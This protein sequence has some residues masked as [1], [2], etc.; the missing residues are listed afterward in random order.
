MPPPL[1]K[2]LWD[3]L[4]SHQISIKHVTIVND[5]A[6][7]SQEFHTKVALSSSPQSISSKTRMCRW[8]SSG[9]SADDGGTSTRN[10]EKNATW[11]TIPGPP[12]PISARSASASPS[13]RISRNGR[14]KPTLSPEEQM[15]K[16]PQRSK[17]FEAPSLPV[18]SK[19]Y[20]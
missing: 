4:H 11:N 2:Y 9:S 5:N 8:S 19:G 3:L 12:P 20:L 14:K 15:R 10:G 7:L 1:N 18:R 16:Q 13:Y 17:S 6:R